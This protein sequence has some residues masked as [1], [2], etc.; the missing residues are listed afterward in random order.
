MLLRRLPAFAP[1]STQF[2]R[3]LFRSNGLSADAIHYHVARCYE[4]PGVLPTDTIHHVTGVHGFSVNV[5]TRKRIRLCR[6]RC[7][8]GGCLLRL[9]NATGT[10]YVQP[11]FRVWAEHAPFATWSSYLEVDYGRE[12]DL[13][14][15]TRVLQK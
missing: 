3:F 8:S 14:Y 10:L 12:F 5:E 11:R 9:N 2:R 6:V 13:F 15:A 4:L 1:R 7:H